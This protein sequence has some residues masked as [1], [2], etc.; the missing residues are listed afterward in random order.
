MARF[1]L[2][3]L[4]VC[5]AVGMTGSSLVA[6][7]AR[8]AKHTPR[9][10]ISATPAPAQ[11]KDVMD[12]LAHHRLTL[13]CADSGVYSDLTYQRALMP[14]AFGDSAVEAVNANRCHLRRAT[15]GD[16]GQVM[17]H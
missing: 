3:V 14:K 7:S 6:R 16:F 13:V 5:V 1:D 12:D 10:T 15:S 4:I 2:A 9:A 11:F 8:T 17:R